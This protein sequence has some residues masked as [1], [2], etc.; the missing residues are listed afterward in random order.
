MPG[1][2]PFSLASIGAICAG[3]LPCVNDVVSARQHTPLLAAEAGAEG[4]VEVLWRREAHRGLARVGADE[5][6]GGVYAEVIEEPAG[7]SVLPLCV[8]LGKQV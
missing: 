2:R 1:S 3:L 5:D 8:E 7:V 6:G 4:G